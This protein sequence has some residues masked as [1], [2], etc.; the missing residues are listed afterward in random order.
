MATYTVSRHSLNSFVFALLHF[1]HPPNEKR[2][3]VLSPSNSGEDKMTA[4]GGR[5]LFLE[6]ISTQKKTSRTG[7]F[8]TW[9]G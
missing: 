5:F 6:N 7:K 3:N 1:F 8:A 9:R 2:K 4:E